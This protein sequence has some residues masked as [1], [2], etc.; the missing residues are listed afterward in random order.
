MSRQYTGSGDPGRSLAL[1][2]RTLPAPTRKRS[3]R[4]DPDRVVAAAVEIAD[5]EGL[6]G[7]SMRKVADRLGVGTMSLYS[8][9]PGRAE[10]AD[11]MLDQ[12]YGELPDPA[13]A[14]P[15]WRARLERAARSTRDLY[16]RHPWTLEI[17]TGRPLL[18]PNAMRR[19]ERE[20][21]ALEGTGL[22]DVEMDAVVAL[23]GD[24]V[25]GAARGAVDADAAERR[26]GISDQE[27]WRA[28]APALERLAGA[29]AFPVADRV[30]SAAARAY[31]AAHDPDREFEFGLARV[32]DGVAAL[33]GARAAGGAG[34]EDPR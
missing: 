24:Y 18:G 11:A 29:G 20:L 31:G 2:W 30:G 13:G 21:C 16:R 3:T 17:A 7:V 10:L 32:L 22:P 8:Y 23:V 25:H 27:W 6:V 5:A 34:P 19:Y 26:T 15:G 14:G 9:V 12:V 33:I 4:L 28:H 1:M